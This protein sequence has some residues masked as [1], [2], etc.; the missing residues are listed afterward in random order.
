MPVRS[1][2]SSLPMSASSPVRTRKV[3]SIAEK[4]PMAATR[5]GSIS[6]IPSKPPGFAIPRAAAPTAASA[7]V[8][9]IEPT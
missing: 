1:D 7:I 3:P 4:I 2:Q 8:A 5:M 9:I 6:S